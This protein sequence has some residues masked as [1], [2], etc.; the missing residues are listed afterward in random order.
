M[1]SVKIKGLLLSAAALFVLSGCISKVPTPSFAR[2]GDVVNIGLGG[3]KRNTGMQLIGRDNLTVTITDANSV[4]HTPQILGTYRVFP[5]HTSIYAVEAQDRNHGD[6]GQL[7]PHDG[8]VWM[9]IRL[10]DPSTGNLPLA[11]GDATIS[12]SSPDLIQTGHVDDGDYASFPI[13]ILPGVGQ[14]SI[15]DNQNLAYQT[16]TYLTVRPSTTAGVSEIGGAQFEI[17]FKS[18]ITYDDAFEMRMVPLN[19]DPNL[20]LIQSIVDNGDG[21]KTLT[22]FLTN[23]NGFVPLASWSQ[24]KSSF[25]DL[26]VGLVSTNG[27]AAFQNFINTMSMTTN[28]FYVDGNGDPIPGISPVFSLN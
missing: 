16:N 24:G 2:P 11:V 1:V 5:D 21:T 7:Y 27:G 10:F 9:T 13:E 25:L 28:S 3:I 15:T 20:S 6:Y 23:P 12:V 22:A 17:T 18:L 19:H 26:H 8:A 14:V 4:V